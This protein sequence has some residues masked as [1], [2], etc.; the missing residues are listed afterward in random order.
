MVIKIAKLHIELI[1]E[2]LVL[3]NDLVHDLY[4]DEVLFFQVVSLSQILSVLLVLPLLPA[5]EIF[6][7]ISAAVCQKRN[8]SISLNVKG[9]K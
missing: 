7:V 9:P 8:I 1:E 6:L 3:F 5:V 4:S 2:L